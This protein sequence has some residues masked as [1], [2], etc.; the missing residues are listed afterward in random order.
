MPEPM[1][2]PCSHCGRTYRKDLLKQC[3]AC[4]STQG[5]ESPRE[6]KSITNP[7]QVSNN[8]FGMSSSK[9]VEVLLAEIVKSTSRTTHAVRAF[10]RFLFIQ[11]SAS[12][13]GGLFIFWSNPLSHKP[14]MFLLVVGA[15]TYVVGLIW[16]SIAGWS[17]LSQ[18]E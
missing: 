1:P 2:S 11:L 5:S 12:T 8:G 7:N 6:S 18:S 16:S 4:A 15:L 17:E 9:Q 13:L 10:V 14:N 3:P